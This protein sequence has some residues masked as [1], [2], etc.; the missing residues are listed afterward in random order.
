MSITRK[1]GSQT[2]RAFTLVELLVV[3]GIIALL[4]SILL[5]SL[6]KA[7]RAASSLKC[8]S[9]LRTIMTAQQMYAARNNGWMAGSANT[10]GLHYMT[11]GSFSTPR[12]TPYFD[13]G[14]NADS[15]I[16]GDGNAP[17]INTMN[18]WQSPLAHAMGIKFNDGSNE[19]ARKQRYM[20]FNSPGSFASCPDNVD[21][22]SIR[23]GT[24][25]DWGTVPFQSYSMA[26]IFTLVNS[27]AP[28]LPAL[29][30]SAKGRTHGQ[31]AVVTDS[32][33]Y[34]P[35]PGYAPKI[36]KIKNSQ[37]KI[38]FADGSRFFSG[39][40][41]PSYDNGL[42]TGSGGMYADRGAFSAASRAQVRDG[43]PANGSTGRDTRLFWARHG[44]QKT[45]GVA[46]DAYK[47]N[48]VFWDGHA[49]TLGDLEGANPNFWMP[50]GTEYI[51]TAASGTTGNIWPDVAKKY[52]DGRTSGTAFAN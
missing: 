9:N 45:S 31:I 27:G 26:F 23:S 15:D 43:I 36:S 19:Y 5:P 44:M 17:F 29:A 12:P 41:F 35:P 20:Q 3:I 49:E 2:R 30:G 47:F 52:L 18:D 13:W 28:K 25:K 8:L 50:T 6:Q 34:D 10:S 11:Q 48:A 46:N 22:V 4:I 14:N 37:S 21:V 42:S 33:A 24:T 51:I 39:T 32:T 38:A 1:C 40:A 16:P 7:K